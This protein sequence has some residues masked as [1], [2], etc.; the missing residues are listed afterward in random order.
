MAN[1]VLNPPSGEK[2]KL[3]V[4]IIKG[5]EELLQC[6][7]I[8]SQDVKKNL[9]NG[10]EEEPLSYK[11]KTIDSYVTTFNDMTVTFTREMAL[12]LTPQGGVIDFWDTW[13]S[14]TAVKDGQQLL[15]VNKEEPF[16]FFEKIEKLYQQSQKQ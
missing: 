13:Y 6:S 11:E 9:Y 12:E 14:I 5:E 4:S 2:R 10:T 15:D 7:Y 8:H 3:L 16:D 1:F